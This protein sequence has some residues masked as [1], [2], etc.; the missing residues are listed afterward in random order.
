MPVFAKMISSW[1]REVLC[2]AQVH[3]CG[4][5]PRCCSFC[6]IGIW[7]FPG[8]I[9]QVGD[10]A[11]ISIPARHYFPQI[12][13]LLIGIMILWS[14][15]SWALMSRWHVLGNCQTLTYIVLQYV[16]LSGCGSPWF[17]TNNSPIVCVVL[18]LYSW[19]YCSGE[20]GLTA[21]HPLLNI[22]H[23]TSLNVRLWDSL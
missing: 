19:D 13:L 4:C 15:L 10:W 22:C 7:C 21:Q 23:M 6:S 1:V 8:C 20:Q 9:L 18:A 11:R 17:K 5:C 2:I 3:V 16:W 12:S 14:M